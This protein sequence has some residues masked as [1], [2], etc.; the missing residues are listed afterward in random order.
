MRYDF[1]PTPRKKCFEF[2][3]A[4]GLGDL[5]SRTV[6]DDFDRARAKHERDAEARPRIERVADF[7]PVG[8]GLTVRVPLPHG[9]AAHART[10]VDDIAQAPVGEVR[11][12]ERGER[13]QSFVRVERA[14]EEGVGCLVREL[15][16]T[17]RRLGVGAPLACLR[18]GLGGGQRVDPPLRRIWGRH[19]GER[20]VDLF[21]RREHDGTFFEPDFR[22]IEQRPRLMERVGEGEGEGGP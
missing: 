4:A 1:A 12:H 2:A 10:L 21:D 16:A 9:D 13:S 5:L 7:E 15:D 19:R 6:G 22:R 3:F 14:R 8:E 20:A 17:L 11:D 18:E